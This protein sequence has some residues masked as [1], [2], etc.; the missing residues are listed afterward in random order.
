L[1]PL[2]A[3]VVALLALAAVVA[4]L[5]F[6][7]DYY[8]HR[9]VRSNADLVKLLPPGDLTIFF[10][11]LAAL[12]Q[13]GLLN[14]LTGVQPAS[15]RDYLEFVRRTEFDYTHDLDALAGAA[16]GERLFFV[17]RGRFHWDKLRQYAMAHGGSCQADSCKAPT[18]KPGRWANFLLIQADVI[19]LALSADT[20]AADLLRPPGRRVQESEH[21]PADP[22]WVRVSPTLLKNPVSLPLPLRIFAITL[23]SAESVMVSLGP[24]SGNAFAFMVKLD[25]GFPNEPTAEATRN[26]CEIQT[27]MLKIELAREHQQPNPADLTGLLTAGSFQVVDKHVTGEWPVRKEL[28]RTLQ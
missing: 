5:L 9:F 27:K 3:N 18:S 8:R 1:R 10:G 11:N 13:A 16:D 12:R 24:A 14:L 20:S 2:K 26:Q 7:I 15:E 28:L 25:A 4:A 22:V 19:G 17:M 6:A 23:Q 21:P